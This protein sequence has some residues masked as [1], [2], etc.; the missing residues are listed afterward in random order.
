[1]M[2]SAPMNTFL[3]LFFTKWFRHKLYE[4]MFKKRTVVIST[5]AGADEGK[6]IK[7]IDT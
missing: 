1:M 6:A 5:A 7:Y 2:P 4:E 3:D